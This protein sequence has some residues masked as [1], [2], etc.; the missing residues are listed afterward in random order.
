MTPARFVGEPRR[1]DRVGTRAITLLSI[2]AA[3]FIAAR[4]LGL[5]LDGLIP[6]GAGLE[7][8]REMFGAALHPALDY[9]SDVVLPGTP[10]F[11]LKVLGGVLRTV[12]FAAAAMSLA[13]PAGLVLALF[14]S[15][16]WWV[17]GRPDGAATIGPAARAI[18][19]SVRFLIALLRSV[20]ELL[21][22]VLFLAALGLNPA[23]A[24]VAIALPFSGTLA[25]VGSEMLDEADRDSWRAL[26]T[27]GASP[28][29]ALVVGL[30]PR[31]T[32]DLIAYAFYRF[33]C[34]LRSAAVLGFF[35][36]PTLGLYVSQSFENLYLREVWTYLYALVALVLV[37]EAW[38]AG[39]RRRLTR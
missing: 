3:A 2:A 16:A 33:E 25:K 9:Q 15:E 28:S 23:A 19:V 31:A 29:A 38:S 17:R 1:V 21:W 36:Y 14:A 5:D 39:L 11:L 24:V 4:G 22:A 32:P 26:W 18:Q 30:L 7:L 35:G 10:P 12:L 27:A 37:V 34:A 20:H 6:R 13:V 8:A